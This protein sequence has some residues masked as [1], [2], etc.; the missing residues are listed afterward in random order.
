LS[1]PTLW[2]KFPAF[3][4]SPPRDWFPLRRPFG[5]DGPP[6]PLPPSVRPKSS[7]SAVQAILWAL[8]PL[9]PRRIFPH[10]RV[11]APRLFF[12]FSFPARKDFC[13]RSSFVAKP[14]SLCALLSFP[15][16]RPSETPPPARLLPRPPAP[17]PFPLPLN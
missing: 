6:P 10:P 14:F 15:P 12:F 7:R 2:R 17:P 9:V 11:L 5:G 16:F 1:R 8:N 13:Q 3:F 4:L